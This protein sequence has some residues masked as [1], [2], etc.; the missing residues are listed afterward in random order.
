MAEN[1]NAR[2]HEENRRWQGRSGGGAGKKKI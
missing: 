1:K 2:S